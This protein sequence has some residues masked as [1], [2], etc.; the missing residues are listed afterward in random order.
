MPLQ[1]PHSWPKNRLQ[2]EAFTSCHACSY[3]W[4]DK[5]SFQT[6]STVGV[7]ISAHSFQT[8]K[9]ISSGPVEVF[10][11]L[12]RAFKTWNVDSCGVEA[13]TATYISA[14]SICLSSSHKSKN[15]LNVSRNLSFKLTTAL[16]FRRGFATNPWNTSFLQLKLYDLWWYNYLFFALL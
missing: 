11:M 8:Q 6:A 2:G 4:L 13:V 9:G 7:T 5:D 3:C 15:L 1:S 16:S 14:G 10:L 12:D